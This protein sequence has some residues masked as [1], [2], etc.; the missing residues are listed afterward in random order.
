LLQASCLGLLG[1]LAIAGCG[2]SDPTGTKPDTATDVIGVRTPA[3]LNISKPSLDFGTVAVGS[4][5]VGFDFVITNVGQTAT[6]VPVAVT[7][8]GPFAGSGCAAA[9]APG[10]S[11]TEKVT[12]TPTAAGAATGTMT[13]AAGASATV[14]ATLTGTGTKGALT[15]SPSTADLLD[16]AVGKTKAGQVVL[17]NSGAGAVTGLVVGVSG[18]DFAIDATTTT[19]KTSLE[20]GATCVVGY[21]LAPKTA[22]DKTGQVSA[23]ATGSSAVAIVTAKAPA[24]AAL[25]IT[26]TLAPLTSNVGVD[27]TAFT[28]TVANSGGTATGNL[29]A[30]I[31]GT[32]KDSFKTTTSTCTSLE[33]RAYCTIAVVFNAAT[34]GEKKAKLTVADSVVSASADLTG[35]STTPGNLVITGGPGLGTVEIGKT[36]T[37][38]TFTVTNSGDTKSGALAVSTGSSEFVITA[39]QCTG[40]DLNSAGTCTVSV[41]LAPATA[42]AKAALLTVRGTSTAANLTMTGTATP[43]S[44]AVLAITP[45]T[46]D[47]GAIPTNQ[48]S[49]PQTFTVTNEGLAATGNLSVAVTGAA[50]ASFTATSTCN[51]PL[52][53]AATCSVTVV[54][55]PALQGALAATLTVTDG[56]TSDSSALSGTGIEPSAISLSGAASV[57]NL[58][59]DCALATKFLSGSSGPLYV[60]PACDGVTVTGSAAATGFAPVVV[61][62]P[63]A[64]SSSYIFTITANV[65]TA[66][67]E[68][69]ALTPA[70]SGDGAADFAI[71]TNT[72]VTSLF[73][74]QTCTVEVKFAPKTTGIRSATFTVTTEKGGRAVASLNAYARP[75]VA[76][77]P[78]GNTAYP[79][80]LPTATSPRTGLV[81]PDQSN[82]AG[83]ETFTF[84]VARNGSTAAS[85]LNNLAITL[86]SNGGGQSDDFRIIANACDS[87]PIKDTV[88]ANNV[89]NLPNPAGDTCDVTVQF[90][91]QTG[92]GL[93]TAILTATGANGGSATATV[94]GNAVGPLKWSPVDA[95]HTGFGDVVVGSSSVSPLTLTLTNSGG[96][97]LGP[98]TLAI[99]STEVAYAQDNCSGQTLAASATCTVRLVLIP[100]SVGAKTGTITATA[101]TQTAQYALTGNGITAPPITVSPNSSTAPVAFANTAN[102]AKSD[103]VVFTVTNPAA[104]ATREITYGPLTGQ[105]ETVATDLGTCGVSGTTRLDPGASCTI[106]VRFAPIDAAIGLRTGTLPVSAVA[107]QPSIVVDLK[108]IATSQI[109][110]TPTSNAF[111]AVAVG[112]ASAPVT[113]TVTNQGAAA[114]SVSTGTVFTNGGFAL[115]AGSC[116]PA[117][118]MTIAAGGTCTFLASMTGAF[119]TSTPAVGATPTLAT[120]GQAAPAV[121][122][123]AV[124]LTAGS[125]S[126]TVSLTG[127]VTNK[128][129]VVPFNFAA[130]DG[131]FSVTPV[132]MGSMLAAGSTATPTVTVTYQNR[133]LWP[134][135]T[136]SA[137]WCPTSSYVATGANACTATDA[138]FSVVTESS[139]CLSVSTLAPKATCTVTVRLLPAAVTVAPKWLNLKYNDGADTQNLVAFQFTG[140]GHTSTTPY[141]TPANYTFAGTTA[142]GSTATATLTFTNPSSGTVTPTAAIAPAAGQIRVTG[143]TCGNGVAVPP[144]QSCTII[145]TF[146]PTGTA[147]PVGRVGTV[148]VTV[149]TDHYYAGVVGTAARPAVLSMVQPG[150]F[151]QR[152][153]AGPSTYVFNDFGSA[154]VGR[155]TPAFSFVVTNDGDV[156]TGALT[157]DIAGTDATAFLA[158]AGCSGALAAH[159]SCT[160]TVT[161][162][163]AAA[164]LVGASDTVLAVSDGGGSLSVS[165]NALN[166]TGLTKATLTRTPPVFNFPAQAVKSPSCYNSVLLTNTGTDRTSALTVSTSSADYEVLTTVP[167]GT[168]CGSQA[169]DTP[170]DPY[171]AGSLNNPNSLGIPG[172][173]GAPGSNTCNV[174]VRFVPQTLP[175]PATINGS[176]TVAGGTDAGTVTV[177]MTGT[178]TSA[179]SASAATLTSAGSITFTNALG[180]PTTGILSTTLATPSN[181]VITANSCV[182]KTLSGVAGTNT[183]SI[184]IAKAAAGAATGTLTVAGTPGNSAA[185]TINIP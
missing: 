51:A 168:I 148:D 47:F 79:V 97:S 84:R 52:A 61:G 90:Y 107:G 88:V 75:L 80:T 31:T 173:G 114:A 82:G 60:Y 184:T 30:V 59:T 1:A 147:V 154:V 182:G 37:P 175:S 172:A 137:Q 11:C 74:N 118:A 43:L 28:F 133:G 130:A 55:K 95:Q 5:S 146:A 162:T 178:A 24:P 73:Q 89:A 98:V 26:P 126:Q 123:G 115:S 3:S 93:K 42:G 119:T 153:V 72:C 152:T 10:A 2:S 142:F 66:A 4:S 108:G 27:S 63:N 120:L 122:A 174:W 121:I 71:G 177:S 99:D 131:S 23:T 14:S 17:S 69:G 117:A 138:E 149:G 58:V 166:V 7:F 36:G 158:S 67:T 179:L 39:D 129:S 76:I 15:F 112:Q 134:A 164:G 86:T 44:V 180:A 38:V 163:P 64:V 103:F 104:V 110:V 54:F 8:T 9:L 101:G 140:E 116:N 132:E 106:K 105:F 20:A 41:A 45:D 96:V 100:T 111:A 25:V 160:V 141:I 157:A 109:V 13:A 18:T 165:S 145:V 56:A 183:C 87:A 34:K 21:I 143:G 6:T 53:V 171:V 156:A 125:S 135:S 151:K 94:T 92:V 29:A 128:A 167:T 185:V 155:S 16:V 19:C 22:G 32:D 62:D 181:I 161:A 169:T 57:D 91:P 139:T 48:N 113:F 78:A 50:A 144:A 65:S 127:S 49:A 124:T 33:P 35:T 85:R 150:P 68:T 159:S 102:T 81:F 83:G 77:Y 176:L 40:K 170:C 70:I 12:F 136:I 46:R